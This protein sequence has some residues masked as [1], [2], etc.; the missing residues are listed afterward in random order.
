M[1]KVEKAIEEIHAGDIYGIFI[2]SGCGVALINKLMEI[3][4]ASNT[5]YVAESPYSKEFQKAKYG[6][7][8]GRIVSAET[9][10]DTFSYYSNPDIRLSGMYSMKINS[11]YVANFQ[12]GDWKEGKNKND[13][14]T[15]GYIGFSY[16]GQCRIYHIS[17]HD[18]L[19][20]K[21]YLDVI[22]NIGVR[23]LESKNE[24]IPADCHIDAAYTCKL[25]GTELKEVDLSEM[26]T[27]MES[28]DL[29][30]FICIDKEGEYKRLEDFFRGK[31]HIVLY[32]GSFNPPHIGHLGLARIAEEK[33]GEKPV[34][35]ISKKIYGKGEVADMK[36]R[37]ECLNRLGF[38]VIISK[39]GFFNENIAYLSKKFTAPIIFV[40]GT[41]TI[42]RVF[43]SSYKV[44]GYSNPW[45]HINLF[46]NDFKNA[47]FLV[48]DRNKFPIANEIKDSLNK[49]YDFV[50]YDC[51]ASSSELRKLK[52]TGDF[53][54]IKEFLPKELFD[55]FMSK[56]T[57]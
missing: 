14:S 42:N 25:D 49:Y 48:V 5:I 27:M 38:N 18:R 30:N 16:K 45:P 6:E 1:S 19:S 4:G 55:K 29:E 8:G 21:D 28:S 26:M 40:V 47:R 37:V 31:K 44:V 24:Y 43:E 10:M 35:L 52:E 39:S 36:F 2:E 15:H 17:I 20:R 50:P 41:D 46:K 22:G 34:L 7:H 13:T 51:P 32:K 53:E 12:I 9:I 57:V 3:P 33:Y 11:V 54:K 56:K 23:I